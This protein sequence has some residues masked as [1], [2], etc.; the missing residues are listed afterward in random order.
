MVKKIKK[1]CIVLI[2]LVLILGFQACRSTQVGD[3]TPMP[4]GEGQPASEVGAQAEPTAD[5]N[6]YQN[7][8]YG[9][10]FSYPAECY[11]G[12]MPR[13]CKEKPPK[14]RR[15]ECLCFLDSTN[16][17]R[18]SM[19]AFLGDRDNLSLALFIV[20]HPDSPVFNPPQGTDLVSWIN[21]NFSYFED[22]PDESNMDLNGISAV[23][24]L[25]PRSSQSP[26]GENIYYLHNDNLFEI[27]LLSV[28]NEDNVELYDQMLSTFRLDE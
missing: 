22:I 26:G 24:V 19:Q 15:A 13:D 23:R 11:F 3:V 12:R 8:K 16:P 10:T 7:E 5:W 25:Y 4:E 18:V 2:S 14:E 9:Y 21:K 20:S 28:D 17:D 6:S 1:T 27:S